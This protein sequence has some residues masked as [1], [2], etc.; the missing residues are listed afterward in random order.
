MMKRWYIIHSQTGY[1]EK[2]R[3]SL[4]NRI[5]RN[6][7]EE[8]ILEIIIPTEQVSEVRGGKKRV[9]QRKFFPGYIL[10]NMELNDTVYAMIKSTPGVTGFIGT[11]KKPTALSQVEADEIL[12]RIE[13]TQAK[14]SLKVIFEEGEQIRV[15]S[16]PFVN[17]NGT[18]D[19]VY[20]EKGKLKASVSIFGRSTP[21]ELEYWQVE[22]I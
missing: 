2:V 17:F 10:I 20:P 21:V 3:R 1:E 9:S 12:K 19:K 8:S 7:L 18:I 5:R 4:E 14:P 13:E 15:T 16:G 6:G 22:K 11:G